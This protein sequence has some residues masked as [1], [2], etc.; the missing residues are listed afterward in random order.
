[1]DEKDKQSLAEEAYQKAHR[2]ELAYGACPQCVLAAIQETV[3]IVDDATIKA[4][5]GLSGGGGLCGDGTCGALVGGLV[6]LSAK[7]GRDRDRFGKGS[8]IGNHQKCKELV[9]RFRAEFGGITCK[10]L[11]QK[12]TGNTYD[13]WQVEAYKAFDKARGQQCAHATGTVTRWVVEM[14]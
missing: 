9:E 14:L 6:A 12:F 10:E 7:R 5:H 3:G 2:Y 13:M 4:V 1:M 11:Q 8:F